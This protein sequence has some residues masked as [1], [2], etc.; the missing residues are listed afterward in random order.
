MIAAPGARCQCGWHEAA[1]TVSEEMAEISLRRNMQLQIQADFRARYM[2]IRHVVETDITPLI[3]TVYYKE[4]G[5]VQV[6]H[7]WREQALESAE[8]MGLENAHDDHPSS[9]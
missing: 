3:N 5:S 7:R 9:R 8:S 2:D 4:A 1:R 6:W